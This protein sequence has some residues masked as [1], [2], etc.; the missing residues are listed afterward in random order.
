MLKHSISALLAVLTVSVATA[1][2]SGVRWDQRWDPQTQT[3]L[4]D[5]GDRAADWMADLPDNMFV[6]HVSIPAA[7]DFVTG[8]NNWR[9]ISAVTGPV[10][11]TC[12]SATMD[13][14]LSGGI[15]GI[16]LRPGYYNPVIGSAKLFLCHGSD[17]MDITFEDG[18]KKLATYL[19]NHPK[20]FFVI[21]IF[22]GNSGN[23]PDRS[24]TL[25]NQALNN[26][27]VKSCITEF[28]P[29][30]TVGE[31]RGKIVITVRE[32]TSY[33]QHP[34]QADI[35]NW[36][37]SFND[38]QR[39]GR[40]NLHS[41]AEV[42]TRL[43]VQDISSN[44]EGS[45]DTKKAHML[46][47]VNFAQ[48]QDEPMTM[49]N[50]NGLYISEWI[51]NF[52]TM[53]TSTI[54]SSDNYKSNATTLNKQLIDDLGDE[55]GR[56]GAGP[57]GIVFMDYCLN[58]ET[59]GDMS[60]YKVIENNFT[61][62]K[63]APVVRY[64]I[65]TDIDW[66]ARPDNPLAGKRIFLRNVG[67]SEDVNYYK[68]FGGGADWGAHA[69]ANYAGHYV[70]FE[71]G[72]N[73]LRLVTTFGALQNKDGQYY[74]DPTDGENNNGTEFLLT[75]TYWDGYPVYHITGQVSNK[76]LTA[77]PIDAA[78]NPYFDT[79]A[80]YVNPEEPDDSDPH[81]MWQ[82]IA[83]TPEDDVQSWT[84]EGYDRISRLKEKANPERG[85]DATFLIPSYSFGNSDSSVSNWNLTAGSNVTAG[86]TAEWRGGMWRAYNTSAN[87]T[88]FSLSTIVSYLPAGKYK[89]EFQYASTSGDV[90]FRLGDREAVTL[91]ANSSEISG[92]TAGS[93]QI[94]LVGEYFNASTENGRIVYEFDKTTNEEETRELVF[95]RESNASGA[96]SFYLDNLR[97]TYYG[98][99]VEQTRI[100]LD[101]P[102]EWNTIIL[103]FDHAVPRELQVVEATGVSEPGEQFLEDGRKI[104]YHVIRYGNDV[105]VIKANYP[106][107]VRNREI[108]A[109]REQ[110]KQSA[111]RRSA[112]SEKV[113]T[114]TGYPTN[115]KNDYHDR[116]GVLTGLTEPR[117]L[118]AESLGYPLSGH[119]PS[120]AE[121][122][123]Q[124]FQRPDGSSETTI[125]HEGRRAYLNGRTA[126]GV[127][128][129]RVYFSY[130]PTTG[131]ADINEDSSNASLVDVATISGIVIRRKVARE[132]AL[133][134]L[135]AGIY[136][137]TGPEGTTKEIRR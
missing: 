137:I 13:E 104:V 118:N 9:A 63:D 93:D 10:N 59:N 65:D 135:P 66:K 88:T 77:R 75:R 102:N 81:Q 19:K 134:G 39:P 8:E 91:A 70:T 25:Y 80:Y 103:P 94:G 11:S 27:D 133:E 61:R 21:H 126:S 83:M 18:M 3:L 38:N 56:L 71:K 101:F 108:L 68:Y 51:M 120:Y 105:D 82:L 42:S 28:R 54:S 48:A 62:G 35:Q 127:T 32:N 60:V 95:F 26:D 40:L 76:R 55:N 4:K 7:H 1:T 2:T 29:N 14:L 46:N 47:L 117:G 36:R 106:Y 22:R 69:V 50:L 119:T 16:D 132:N 64:Q 115:R 23:Q 90:K 99:N 73:G 17:I 41:N 131:I 123:V 57:L 67:A 130:D 30:L 111:P 109:E 112:A 44:S 12:Q 53:Q 97:L 87:N 107:L 121:I 113:Y 24:N 128:G 85:M 124:Y 96:A 58:S 15:R 34:N 89:L 86:Q 78:N 5:Q 52:M 136:L 45:L 98:N 114:F 74:C 116:S 20:E 92:L 100:D 129:E 72:D 84:M 110:E 43:H 37:T 49:Y 33:L 122:P 125:H 79:P 6:A 31:A